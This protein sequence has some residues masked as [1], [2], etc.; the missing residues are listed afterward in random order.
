M[1]LF[2]LIPDRSRK[3]Q[4]RHRRT[5]PRLKRAVRNET[6]GRRTYDMDGVDPYVLAAVVMHKTGIRIEPEHIKPVTP[7]ERLTALA[8]TAALREIV[9]DDQFIAEAEANIERIAHSRR[10]S[11][12]QPT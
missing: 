9:K 2:G 3:K 6:P 10:R 5:N 8:I 7:E 1:A 11:S 12:Q 4:R